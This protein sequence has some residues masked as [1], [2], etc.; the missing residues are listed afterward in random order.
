MNHNHI[1][2][3]KHNFTVHNKKISSTE[4]NTYIGII[5]SDDNKLIADK[6]RDYK[7]RRMQLF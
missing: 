4:S 1:Q 2:W 7:L 6:P 3:Q 5:N